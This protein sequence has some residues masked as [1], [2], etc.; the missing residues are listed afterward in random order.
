MGALLPP[1]ALLPTP[2]PTYYR[3]I[4]GKVILVFPGNQPGL[5]GEGKSRGAKGLHQPLTR[6]GVLTAPESTRAG[7]P[8]SAS[9]PTA[10]KP[11]RRVLGQKERFPPGPGLKRT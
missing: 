11:A 9:P 4:N 6:R 10:S 1:Y 3:P 5:E 2:L 8:D 7:P